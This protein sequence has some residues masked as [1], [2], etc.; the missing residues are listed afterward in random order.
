ML[1]LFGEDFDIEKES[2]NWAFGNGAEFCGGGV[3]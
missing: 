1:F 2:I 3:T